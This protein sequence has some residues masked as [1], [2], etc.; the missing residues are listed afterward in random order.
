[1]SDQNGV[2]E[3]PLAIEAE[4]ALLGSLLIYPEILREVEPIV[5]PEQF[6]T[7]RYRWGYKAILRLVKDR[8]AVDILTVANELADMR[9]LDE[10]GGQGEIIRLMNSVPS[11]L[12]AETYAKEINE[13]F[14]RN[15]MLEV[16]SKIAKMAHG[17]Q[18]S[19]DKIQ[20]RTVKL[21][22][23][24]FIGLSYDRNIVF[25]FEAINQQYDRMNAAAQGSFPGVPTGF[26][27]LDY[28]LSG[29]PRAGDLVI[30][31]GRPGMGK[32]AI[33]LDIFVN[34]IKRKHQVSDL[35][36]VFFSLEMPTDQ[37]TDR[38][39]AKEGIS[40]SN[41]RSGKL[42]DFEYTIYT[43]AI[44]EYSKYNFII[45][46]TPGLQPHEVRSI[47]AKLSARYKIEN[48]FIDYIQLMTAETNRSEN[49]VQEVSKISRELKLIAREF[50][51]VMYAGAQL[52]RAV[53]QRANKK[54][55]LSDLRESGS[56]EQDADIVIFMYRPE[57]Y[58][59][60][61]SY[62]NIAYA[63]VSKHRN[64]PTGEVSLIF[65]KHLAKFENAVVKSI[66]LNNIGKNEPLRDITV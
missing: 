32:T 33:M 41:I 50:E 60:D 17:Q 64:G 18:W 47:L 61:A 4:E 59:D 62:Q 52:S 48:V 51:I 12:H 37:L 10:F 34:N 11:A 20:S 19:L 53:E 46:D 13:A 55:V 21:V 45:I 63:I 22:Q 65:R 38:M 43:A 6:Y 56:L 7:E 49:R 31:G 24:C 8:K 29:G 25:A 2:I 15:E 23:D 35:H 58:S 30:I 44:E 9:R 26:K 1:M 27:D 66:D 42:E 28:L 16:S 40:L 5:K 57:V 39:I 14:I 54:P 36:D 3:R